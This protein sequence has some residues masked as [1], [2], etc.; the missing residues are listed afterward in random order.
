MAIQIDLTE[1]ASRNTGVV[2][3]SIPYTVVFWGRVKV[4]P[5]G[6]YVTLFE[7]GDLAGAYVGIYTNP[8]DSDKFYLEATDGIDVEQS[9]GFAFTIKY[10]PFAYTR[11]GST[12]KFYC[13]GTLIG[14]ITLDLSAFTF[15]H[16]TL[17]SV[18]AP[19][20]NFN[21]FDFREWDAE[22]TLEE[23]LL[24]WKS[25]T[26][27]RTADLVSDIPLLSDGDDDSGNGNDF[28][29]TG[30]VTFQGTPRARNLVPR[31]AIEVSIPS[32][33]TY[34]ANDTA[35][36]ETFDLIFTYVES[37]GP[38]SIGIWAF[39]GTV[40][41]GYQPK[42]YIVDVDNA[43]AFASQNPPTNRPVLTVNENPGATVYF[44]V[45][46]NS[47]QATA[48]AE[49]SLVRH[50]PQTPQAGDYF[51]TGD[52]T[53]LP[54]AVLIPGLDYGVRRIIR[55][56]LPAC[57]NGDILLTG[58]ILLEDRDTQDLKLFS[59]TLELLQTIALS[60]ADEYSIRASRPNN[61]FYTIPQKTSPA[62]LRVVDN[63]GTVID[64]VVISGFAQ[65]AWAIAPNN[66]LS[67]LYFAQDNINA[68]VQ[69]FNLATETFD[70]TFVA[71]PAGYFINEIMVLEDDTI[72]VGY[73]RGADDLFI[74]KRFDS[75][76][77]ELDSY[78]FTYT[79]SFPPRIGYSVDSPNSFLVFNQQIDSVSKLSKIIEVNVS[80]GTYLE[81]T[82]YRIYQ[83][84]GFIGPQSD[85]PDARFG[86][87]S[88]CAMIQLVESVGP[89]TPPTGIFTPVPG[90][91]YDEFN[92]QQRVRIP[93]PFFKTYFHGD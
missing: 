91:P 73:Y 77:T 14:T 41:S 80:D 84:F 8:A 27:V 12:H 11:T 30:S 21:V 64:S 10:L 71:T 61:L 87:S 66:D 18:L 22:L 78:S 55:G 19:A 83:N 33:N 7:T 58:R 92:G 40:D 70:G 28:S 25:D 76:G 16:V 29:F 24:E 67:I 1:D 36:A 35:D 4:D 69:K 75:A 85:T 44:R 23:L 46:K 90:Q 68:V 13:N 48:D 32:N 3:T 59:P 43:I 6:N 34:D 65:N 31:T 42:I 86:P 79:E 74:V 81:E 72:L 50:N 51:I 2:S 63:T 82:T 26:V 93:T 45:E 88:S 49:L 53:N 52:L 5:A 62:T 39:G 17:S 54:S 56:D 15:N 60:D 37:D 89:P 47:N 20:A 57:D 9:T 38:D